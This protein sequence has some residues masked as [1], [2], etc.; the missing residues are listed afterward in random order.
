M[1]FLGVCKLGE[2]GGKGCLKR[3]VTTLT[4]GYRGE[5]FIQKVQLI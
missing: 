5:E 1:D 3:C 2:G 4:E